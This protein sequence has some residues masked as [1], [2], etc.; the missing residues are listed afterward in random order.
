MIEV[1]CVTSS[2]A[3][4]RGG[5]LLYSSFPLLPFLQCPGAEDSQA[6]ED[7]G[8]TR[9]KEPGSLN[10][11]VEESLLLTLGCYVS[12]KQLLQCY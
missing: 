3:L 7:D 6:L 11:H 5:G 8:A 2:L 10:P 12:E 1:M 4:L 9:Q